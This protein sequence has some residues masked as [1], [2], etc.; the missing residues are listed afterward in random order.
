MS[1]NDKTN[2]YIWLNKQGS[3]K[4]YYIV[5]NDKVSKTKTYAMNKNFNY[6]KIE[7]E[8]LVELI[9][10]SFEKYPRKYL[11]ELD[12]KPITNPTYLNWLRKISDVKNINNDMMRSSYINWYYENYKTLS[13]KEKLSTLMRHSVLTAQ[14]NYLKVFDEN[15]KIAGNTDD[16]I[17]KIRTEN[18]TLKNKLVNC[19]NANKLTEVQFNKRRRDVIYKANKKEAE[20]KETTLTKYKIIFD[21]ISKKYV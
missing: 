6:I 7:N 13:D 2:N 15:E 21:E 11:F 14:R 19:A 8:N 12:G 1:D 4:V 9:N 3:L 16:E 17:K 5:N 10:D 20:I 18:E